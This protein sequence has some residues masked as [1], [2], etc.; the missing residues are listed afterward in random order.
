[1]KQRNIILSLITLVLASATFSCS[2]EN[3]SENAGEAQ[4][5]LQVRLTDAPAAYSEI[6]VDIRSVRVN[7]RGDSTGWIDLPTNARVYNLLNFQN[8]ID[9]SLATGVVPTGTV[10]EVRFILGPNNTVVENGRTYPLVLSSQ[11]E[12]GLKIKVSK[13]V[14]ASFETMV[15]DFD[16]AQSVIKQGNGVY[17]LKPVLKL[18]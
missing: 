10:K 11:D 2:K 4:S 5:T 3:I 13:K 16:A 1:M 15:I 8:G 18:K 7:L 6:N 9:T 14:E 17:R 12:A